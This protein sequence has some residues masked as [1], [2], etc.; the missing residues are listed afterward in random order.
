LAALWNRAGHYIFVL[1][2]LFVLSFFLPFSSQPS[3][4][5]CL[6]YFHTWCGLSA[7]LGCRSETCCTRLAENTGRKNRQKFAICAP[8]H[9][10]VGL[11]SSQLRHVSTIG[12]ILVK[13]HY[14][15]HNTVNCAP[16]AA[17]IGSL[18]SFGHPSKFQ[19]VSRLGF[20]TGATSLN[21]SQP[22]FA[23][24]LAVSWAG[25]HYILVYI[26][27]GYC[28]VTEFCQVQNSLCVQVLRSPILT[29]LL[30]GIR[31]VGV[32]QTLRR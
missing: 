11:L 16:L 26:F 31:V 24:C 5:G 2:F 15:I 29:A 3:E 1:W 22:N 17:E 20:V 13:Q 19:R 25:I 32:S 30:H 23:R 10:F 7:N 12:N 28:P 14:L 9:N 8:S 6:P 4:I 21:G 27:G 18:Y